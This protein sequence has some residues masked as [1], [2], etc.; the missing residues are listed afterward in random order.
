[1]DI[2]DTHITI[3]PV[4]NGGTSKDYDTF[5]SIDKRAGVRLRFI[6]VLTQQFKDTDL[7]FSLSKS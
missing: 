6:K 3:C 7:T 1:M 4:G 5:I 2:Y